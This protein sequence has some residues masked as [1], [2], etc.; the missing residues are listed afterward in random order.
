MLLTLPHQDAHWICHE[1]LVDYSAWEMFFGQ[2]W[3]SIISANN[4]GDKHNPFSWPCS[5]YFNKRISQ[6]TNVRVYCINIENKVFNSPPKNKELPKRFF[7]SLLCRLLL[8]LGWLGWSTPAFGSTGWH[9]IAPILI[10]QVSS[11]QLDFRSRNT[12]SDNF[13]Y[14]NCTDCFHVRNLLHAGLNSLHLKEQFSSKVQNR[15]TRVKRWLPH[16]WMMECLKEQTPLRS[17]K[18]KGANPSPYIPYSGCG[19]GRGVWERQQTQ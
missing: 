6:R 11:H 19:G 3:Y 13:Q 1:I 16:W 15:P 9:I 8:M 12:K 18:K 2:R 10:H 4:R 14:L 5:P 7:F 17:K